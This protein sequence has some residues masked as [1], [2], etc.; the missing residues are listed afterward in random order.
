M[1]FRVADAG[2]VRA[3]TI[4]NR[5]VASRGSSR[6]SPRR[7]SKGPLSRRVVVM[8][9]RLQITETSSFCSFNLIIRFSEML[10]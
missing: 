1:A 9:L 2:V 8:H 4:G 6:L 3:C 5:A 10:C 7:K